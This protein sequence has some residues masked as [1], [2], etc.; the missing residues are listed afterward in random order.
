[1]AV[2]RRKFA[3][4]VAVVRSIRE[5][6]V[7]F[8]PG[9]GGN[10]LRVRFY[11][12]RLRALGDNVV[13]ELGA[14]FVNPEYISIGDNCWID[15]YVVLMAGPPSQ[16]ERKIARLENPLFKYAEGELVIERNCHIASH[17]VINAHGGVSIGENTTIAAGAKVISL[18][19][20]H[21]NLE[22]DSDTF[23][24][25]FGSRAPEEEQALISHPIVLGKNAGLGTNAVMVPGSSIGAGSW[26][27]AASFVREAIPPGYLAWGVPAKPTRNRRE[28][29]TSGSGEDLLARGCA[30]EREELSEIGTLTTEDEKEIDDRTD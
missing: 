3:N 14:Q 22:D 21:R 4:A 12:R 6:V 29:L 17:V 1:V 23:L 2:F 30:K 18:S 25:R 16:G 27:G 11:R 10:L 28:G 5:L 8:A 20:H 7:V 13:I 19:H 9:P 15:K 26:V 24:Y